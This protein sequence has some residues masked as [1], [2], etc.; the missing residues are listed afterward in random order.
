MKALQLRSRLL[1]LSETELI[2]ARN[3]SNSNSDPPKK[4]SDLLF[5][6]SKLSSTF[7]FEG[8]R[9]LTFGQFDLLASNSLECAAV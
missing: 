1:L 8:S 9:A 4:R 5:S 3:T 7:P 6:R 2:I